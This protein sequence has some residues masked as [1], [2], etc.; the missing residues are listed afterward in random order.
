MEIL[1]I[2]GLSGAGKSS[3]ATY[4]EDMGYYTVDNVPAD[5]ILK[6]AE[7]CSQSDGRYDRVALVS[8]IRSG[9]G[10]F[11]GILDAMER[12]KQGGYRMVVCD[13]VTHTIAR[14]M[15][16]DAFL[17]TSGIESLHSAID[18]AVNISTWFGQLRQE[19]LFLRS[20]TQEQGGRVVVMEPDGSL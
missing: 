20:I 3:A 16:F 19:N 17:I 11:Q 18:Q 6:F 13:M 2:S 8:D 14:E 4:L 10:N 9:N 12:L 1:I 7:F 15:G 5:I